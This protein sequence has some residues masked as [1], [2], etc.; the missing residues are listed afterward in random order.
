MKQA[1]RRDRYI[2][3]KQ[4]TNSQDSYGQPVVNLVSATNWWAEGI[5][6]GSAKESLVAHQTY[7]EKDVT[8]ITQHTNPTGSGGF[9]LRED[10]IITYDGETFNI[11]GIEELGRRD[12]LRIFAKRK[13]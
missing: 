7:P 9:D 10:D 6:K 1:G 5:F 8:F 11:L 3:I 2:T 12:G 13:A 4:I